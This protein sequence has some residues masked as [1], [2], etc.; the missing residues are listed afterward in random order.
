MPS[1]T[2]HDFNVSLFQA[3]VLLAFNE[4]DTFTFEEL[5][6]RTGM[7]EE[8]A[9]RTLQSLACGKVRVLSKT[10]MVGE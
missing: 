10:P 6:G 9:V 2:T 4:G 3:V 8:E 1:G 7:E 5:K